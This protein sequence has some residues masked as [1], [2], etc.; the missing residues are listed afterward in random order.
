MP[1]PRDRS[2]RTP[3]PYPS[4]EGAESLRS[5]LEAGGDPAR[6]ALAS[7]YFK[8]GPGGYAEGDR[9]LGYTVPVLRR[10]ALAHPFLSIRGSLHLLE[11]PFNEVRLLGLLIL[12]RRYEK[13]SPSDQEQVYEAYMG[14]RSRINNWN[15][16]DSSAPQIVG[17]HL[18]AR[19]RDPI[20]RLAASPVLW[21]RRIAIVSTL[22][23]IRRGEFAGTLELA[24]RLLSDPEDLIHKAAGWMLREVGKKDPSTLKTF[25]ATHAARMPRT[26]L[27]Y[28]IERFSQAERAAYLAR[29]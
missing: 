19:P 24:V 10:L 7:R 12:V 29:R 17:A 14:H 26:E 18:H 15:L 23:W 5:E 2:Q 22:A 1:L 8:T 6:G 11:S 28:A 4:I 3:T 27:R 20:A 9:F 13:G 25:L 21:D 16:V